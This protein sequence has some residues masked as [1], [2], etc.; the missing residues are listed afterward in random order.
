MKITG[1]SF[2]EGFLG[3]IILTA[4]IDDLYSRDA[5][6]AEA[7]QFMRDLAAGKMVAH[8]PTEDFH[9]QRFITQPRVKYSGPNAFERTRS[10]E[11][12]G[13]P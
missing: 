10:S 7:R 1:F 9:A 13:K 5:T 6:R 12:L 2:R 3:R 11:D 4:E 8:A